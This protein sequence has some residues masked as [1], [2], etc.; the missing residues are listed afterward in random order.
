MEFFP[1]FG[2]FLPDETDQDHVPGGRN[3]TVP[4]YCYELF[5]A[6]LSG[7]LGTAISVYRT[8]PQRYRTIPQ[9]P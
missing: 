7:M 1:D 9:D 8:I 6:N 4:D 5:R 3:E 2:D